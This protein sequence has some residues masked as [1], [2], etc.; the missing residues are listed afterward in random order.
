MIL[1]DIS[2]FKSEIP[3]EINYINQDNIQLNSEL[4]NS[5]YDGPWYGHDMS[6]DGKNYYYK[7]NSNNRNTS[8]SRG[9]GNERY[10]LPMAYW[11]HY[12]TKTKC[13][14]HHADRVIKFVRK[15]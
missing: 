7:G 4:D 2:F 11:N 6:Y 3:K 13:G 10:N 12:T 8:P 15:R 9:C 1:S 5:V 14:S